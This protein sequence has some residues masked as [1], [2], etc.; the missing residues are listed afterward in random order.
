M[1]R[2]YLKNLAGVLRGYLKNLVSGTLGLTGDLGYLKSRA[3]EQKVLR[4]LVEEKQ[5]PRGY[6]KREKRRLSF[7][8]FLGSFSTLSSPQLG[9]V[10]TL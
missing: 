8:V 1:L 7:I 4:R 6:Q 2:R 9:F 10:G 3:Q 5:V